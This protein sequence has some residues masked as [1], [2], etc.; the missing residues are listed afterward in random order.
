V[1]FQTDTAR[2][3]T[4]LNPAWTEITGLSLYESLGKRFLEL[5]HPDDRQL[6]TNNF[7]PSLVANAKQ[8]TAATSFAS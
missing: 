5:I 2:R 4:F 1:I 3:L 8:K 7:N 6:M